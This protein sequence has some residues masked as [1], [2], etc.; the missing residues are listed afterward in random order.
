[1]NRF[2]W[3]FLVGWMFLLVLGCGNQYKPAPLPSPPTSTKTPSA[4]VSSPTTKRPEAVRAPANRAAVRLSTGMALA[5]T[6]PEGTMMGFSVDYVAAG[7][8]PAT[9]FVWVL[10]RREGDPIRIEVPLKSSGTLQTFVPWLPEDGPFQCH[11]EDG[12]GTAISDSLAL[13]QGI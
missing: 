3:A 7:A 12:Q 11:L 13:R 4:P 10:Q 8:L 6:L 5:Q 2:R 1:M 9:R